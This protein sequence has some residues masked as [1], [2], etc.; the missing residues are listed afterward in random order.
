[1]RGK[2]VNASERKGKLSAD[3]QYRKE[4]F[5]GLLDHIR[6]GYSMDC[7]SLIT[8]AMIDEFTKIFPLEFPLE[9]IIE[10]QR[11]AKLG[12]E[13]IGREQAIGT[14]LGNSRSWYY[15]MSNRYGWSDRVD[16]KAKTE[17]SVS[18]NIVSYSSKK[19][20]QPSDD[21]NVTQ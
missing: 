3:P 16:L 5:K 12:W 4:V 11:D 8:V 2:K 15:N 19:P 13:R 9:E 14:C 21:A 6:Q 18:V 1:M 17:G 20:S 7:Y 10:A